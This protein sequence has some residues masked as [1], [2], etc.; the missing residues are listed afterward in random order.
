MNRK[1]KSSSVPFNSVNLTPDLLG[2]S[3]QHQQKEGIRMRMGWAC[4]WWVH[5]VSQTSA[6]LTE[7]Q[8]QHVG[9]WPCAC[10]QPHGRQSWPDWH[11]MWPAHN[12]CQKLISPHTCYSCYRALPTGKPSGAMSKELYLQPKELLLWVHKKPKL[13][14]K[15]SQFPKSNWRSTITKWDQDSTFLKELQLVIKSPTTF[16]GS[17]D[18]LG[19]CIVSLTW[20]NKIFPIIVT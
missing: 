3:Q 13:L 10:T 5:W 17:R 4:R 19:S 1:W 11:L 16:Q 14:K 12:P 8:P 15:R 7:N 9:D 6:W 20:E 2:D 18:L